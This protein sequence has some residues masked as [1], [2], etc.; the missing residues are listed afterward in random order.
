MDGL[1]ELIRLTGYMD[2]EQDG[3]GRC[4]PVIAGR[5][6]DEIPI[7]QAQMPNGRK[8]TLLKTMLSSACERNC[9]YCPFRAGR[10]MR[11]ATYKPE[12]MARTFLAL[13]SAGVVEGIFLSSGVV[14][15]GVRT[16]DLLIDTAEI[17]RNKLKFRGYLHLKIMPGA[18]R[19]Q[20]ARA[21]HLASRISVNLEAP[22]TDRLQ[23]LAPAKVFTQELL[24][25]L[26]WAEE[27]RRDHP[28]HRTWNGR[29][30]STVTQF[31]VGAV[32]ESDVELLATS[33]GLYRTA[34][35]ARAYYSRFSPVADTPFENL[36]AGSE[37][38]QHRLYQASF[39]LRDYG[40]N[41]EEMAFDTGGNLLQDRDP[42]LAWA[43]RH[44]A[45]S[46]LE[47][48]QVA[49]RDLLR[50]PGIGPKGA[51]AIIVGRQQNRIRSLGDLRKL[52]VVADR[53]APYVLL[54]GRRASYQL[55]MAI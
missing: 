18:E 16:Q 15:G 2:L 36:P 27:I 6:L 48:N 19:D 8:I 30:P 21:M 35:L 11:R 10:D 9:Y 41:M 28:P 24:Q 49:R 23:K 3:D 26:V 45:H 40:F 33:E 52:G 22:N 54:D 20:V 43:Q 7:T 42:K 50:I 5:Q 53:A 46:P 31:V 44:L 51:A 47:I 39:L 4:A 34:G 1:D 37:R 32:G 17:L 13:Y 25:P 29:W 14:G 55:G 12:E 38:R